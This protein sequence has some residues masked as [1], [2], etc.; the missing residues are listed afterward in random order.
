M[1]SDLDRSLGSRYFLNVAKISGPFLN[2]DLFLTFFVV[3]VLLVIDL[4]SW[5]R[6]STIGKWRYENPL[7]F[8]LIKSR[9]ELNLFLGITFFRATIS[10]KR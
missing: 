8:L 2:F 5:K 1:I 10:C 6:H 9:I 3:G 4:I 7:I